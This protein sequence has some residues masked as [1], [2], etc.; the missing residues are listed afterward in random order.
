MTDYQELTKYNVYALWKDKEIVYIGQSTMLANRIL[1]HAK[2]KDF[3]SYSYFECGTKDEMD[4]IESN[5]IILLEPKY[6]KTITSGYESLQ[7]FRKRVEK[8]SDNHKGNPE[9]YVNKIREEL[10]ENDFELTSFKGRSMISV[11]DVPKAL[12]VFRD[13][14]GKIE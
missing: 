6:N 4:L 11:K 8:I 10:L 3:D 7:R 9:Y 13:E 12:R 1:A 2:T 14:A 5:L